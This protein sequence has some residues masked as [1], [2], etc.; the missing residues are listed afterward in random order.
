MFNNKV[1]QAT[2]IAVERPEQR[3]VKPFRVR[4]YAPTSCFANVRYVMVYACLE[5]GFNCTYNRC[6]ED[7]ACNVTHPTTADRASRGPFGDVGGLKQ[8]TR[9]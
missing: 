8:L 6:A 5:N 2:F 3:R 1:R 9:R 4:C 7:M